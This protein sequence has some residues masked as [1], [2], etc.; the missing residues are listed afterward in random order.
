MKERQ[1]ESFFGKRV[2][3]NNLRL[4]A[5]AGLGQRHLE[6]VTAYVPGFGLFFRPEL[7]LRATLAKPSGLHG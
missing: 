6:K 2:R 1:A 5:K 7:N 4:S 3:H